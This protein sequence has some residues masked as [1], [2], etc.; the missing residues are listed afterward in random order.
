MPLTI[1]GSSLVCMHMC[2]LPRGKDRL[3]RSASSPKL[4]MKT[5]KAFTLFFSPAS[6]IF[7]SS[8]GS[9]PVYFM[10]KEMVRNHQAV[11]P[12]CTQ[13]THHILINLH[14]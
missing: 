12:I 13:R 5:Q 6:N 14:R 10:L 8:R 4:A 11:K 7:P 1:V 3:I 9:I 2:P